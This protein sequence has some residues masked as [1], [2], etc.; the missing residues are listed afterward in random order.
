MIWWTI[1]GLEKTLMLR[2]IGGR[3]RREQQ[4]MRWLDGI[5]DTMD[6]GLGRLRELVMDREAWR[7]AIHGV[8]KSR[9]RLSD[10]TELDWTDGSYR[11]PS[12]Q[13]IL[14]HLHY[15]TKPQNTLPFSCHHHT[16][17]TLSPMH[18][19]GYFVSIGSTIVDIS[20]KLNDVILDLCVWN[21]FLVTGF[22]VDYQF[23]IKLY[24]T[25]TAR[26]K[27]CIGQGMWEGAQKFY[28]LWACHSS[29]IFMCSPAQKHFSFSKVYIKCH[30]FPSKHCFSW[31]WQMLKH[32]IFDVKFLE[33]FFYFFLCAC[34]VPQLCCLL[35]PVRLCKNTGVDGRFLLQGFFPTQGSNLRLL[36]WQVD[37]LPLSQ[38]PT[39]IRNVSFKL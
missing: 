8:A 27:R 10:W 22:L 17:T 28:A 36:R 13:L 2:G 35:S 3:R 38:T 6:M 5:T 9:T 14:E 33:P 20:K 25:G 19:L 30:T 1:D 18:L 15:L 37:S 12:L 24:N 31:I 16:F 39:S 4:R 26:W 21:F 32:C 7:D 23:I 29:W 34:S 11:Q